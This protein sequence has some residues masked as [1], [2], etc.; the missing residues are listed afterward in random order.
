V[1]IIFKKKSSSTIFSPPSYIKGGKLE[2]KVDK[3]INQVIEE[4]IFNTLNIEKKVYIKL[5]E[6]FNIY[7][8][9]NTSEEKS[10][11]SF[12]MRIKN[13]IYKEFHEISAKEIE[14][15]GVTTKEFE[16]FLILNGAK[17]VKIVNKILEEI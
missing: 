2:S 8:T 12:R 16:N 10:I 17:K 6:Y 11:Y 13:N 3:I 1:S 15:S 9:N 7:T 4:K 5:V 14:I